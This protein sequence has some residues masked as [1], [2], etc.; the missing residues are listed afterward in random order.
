MF[1]RTLLVIVGLI[2]M[3][4][5]TV[6]AKGETI[7][8]AAKNS[9]PIR[10]AL[11]DLAEGH[12][13]AFGSMYARSYRVVARQGER[14]CVEVVDGPPVPYEG[15]QWITVSTVVAERDKAVVTANGGDFRINSPEEFI[16]DDGRAG[17]WQLR[18][19][20]AQIFSDELIDC[21]NAKG[22]YSNIFEGRFI[23]GLVIG[24][25]AAQLV[26]EEAGARI[27][28]REQPEMKADILHY[29]LAGDSIGL[30]ASSLDAVGNVWYQV[31]FKVSGAE[32]WVHSD[33]VKREIQD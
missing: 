27:Y 4:G 14:L 29:G 5:W 12:Y 32:G 33:L 2:A 11:Q 8:N 6:D 3:M 13:F 24:N 28:V 9:I 1:K 16:I 26:S 19:D 10:E 7:V 22:Q 18:G 21:L 17:V 31:K 23:P 15:R 30:K 20:S 25:T